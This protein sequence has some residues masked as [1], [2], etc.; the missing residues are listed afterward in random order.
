MGLDMYLYTNSKKVCEKA[1]D[2]TGGSEWHKVSGIAMYWRKANAIHKWFVDNVQYGEDDCGSYEVSVE[3]L[4]EL[5]KTC[6]K[7]L[8]STK[9]VE[10]K[11]PNGYV[12]RDGKMVPYEMVDGKVLED[13]SV[14]EELLP[15]QSGFFFG[16]TEYDEWYWNDLEMTVKGIDAIMRS[17]ERFEYAPFGDD[18][19]WKEW[20]EKGEGDWVIKFKYHSS[21]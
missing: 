19:K 17:V 13:P 5:R 4:K 7:V 3:Q 2:A 1:V 14:A 8:K 11:V 15:T 10:T 6:K 20:R 12:M 18:Y 16:G 9:L 21:W